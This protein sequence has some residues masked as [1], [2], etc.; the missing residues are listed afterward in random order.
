MQ[1]RFMGNRCA[2]AV[3]A[4]AVGLFLAVCFA[5]ATSARTATPAASAAAPLAAWDHK[6]IATIDPQVFELA[7]GA[8]QCAVRAGRVADP[9]TLTVIDY[10]KPST[11][12]RLWVF[13]LHSRALLYQEFVAHGQGSGDNLATTFS[14]DAETH[15]S[16]IGLFV[17][18]DTYIGKNGYS[19]RLDGLDK[20]FNDHARDRAIVMHGAPYVSADFAHAHG[21]LGR[22]WGC[23]ALSDTVARSVIDR[24]KNGSLVFSYYPDQRWLQASQYLG[25]CQAAN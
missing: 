22:S 19:L 1:Q 5:P 6:A 8:A 2:R 14:N 12:R 4:L 10:S 3:A 13:D 25:S 16:S 17:T 18:A 9:Q 21:R 20:G 15:R 11:A 23:P 7:L 24:V